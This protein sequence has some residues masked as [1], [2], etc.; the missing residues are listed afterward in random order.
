MDRE[1][2]V[3]GRPDRTP[4]TG[5][6]HPS[7][8]GRW[9][10]VAL[11]WVAFFLNQADRQVFNVVLPLI[12]TD[13]QIRDAAL[14]A[15][16]TT[17]TIVY[18]LLVPLSGWLGDVIDRRKVVVISLLTFSTGTLLTGFASSFLLLLMYRGIATGAGEAL[19]APA[20]A[21]LIG[22]AHVKTRARALSLH[23]TANYTGIV[24]GSLISG[25]TAQALGWRAAFLIYGIAG[26]AWGIFLM[27]RLRGHQPLRDA[28][29][30]PKDWATTRA[31]VRDSL[32]VI[33]GTPTIIAHM[34][35]FGGLIFVLVG[36][37]TWTP[38]LLFERFGVPIA[39]AGFE[40][41]VYHHIGAYAGLA[42]TS[43]ATDRLMGR[44][45]RVR[46]LSM[47]FGLIGMVPF[48]WWAASAST[49]WQA[50]VALGLFGFFRGIYDA[51]IFAAIFDV[52]EDRLR[53]TVTGIL[54]ASGF[55]IGAAS[56]SIMGA[57][58]ASYGLEGG[59]QVL[60]IAALIAGMVLGITTLLD[61]P[62][63]AVG[64][65]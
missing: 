50:Y 59:M 64:A 56:P 57:M 27:W 10:I 39:Y 40:A 62:N 48:I 15:I 55:L 21:S 46:L 43:W 29:A 38:T 60:A 4:L 8:V 51:G 33:A 24:L 2:A 17:F 30:A 18:G 12:R 54:L 34:I 9:E 25:L 7:P 37:L 58:K 11:L 36:F 26:L 41:V 31:T 13:L 3:A 32:A 49:A 20:A 23:Q 52:V 14:G 42:L 16:A 61:R 44:W 5:R 35:G 45:P 19:Y 1:S 65:L 22:E 6:G 53:S 63:R 47:A 28:A